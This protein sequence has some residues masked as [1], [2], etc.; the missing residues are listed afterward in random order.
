MGIV[1]EGLEPYQNRLINEVVSH[2]RRQVILRY[3]AGKSWCALRAADVIHRAGGR[4]RVVGIILCRNRNIM[5][6]RDEIEKRSTTP[7]RIRALTKNG[8]ETV[9]TST[10]AD[11]LFEAR[12]SDE[13]L[14]VP[15]QMV[16][17]HT[18]Y[19]VDQFFRNGNP[20]TLILDESTKIK[21]N[22]TA[23]AAS[24]HALA[25]E[26]RRLVPRGVR[27]GLT[28][29]ATP[30]GAYELW[31]QLEFVRDA[32]H[33]IAVSYWAMLTEYFTL[34]DRGY[35]LKP[36][37][38]AEFYER[39]GKLVAR[40][41]KDE[42]KALKAKDPTVHR[43][44]VRYELT[45]EQRDLRSQLLEK[46]ELS[47]G[48]RLD[49]YNYAMQLMAKDQQISNGFWR[50]A[51]GTTVYLKEN[52]KLSALE[53]IVQELAEERRTV[54]RRRVV[55]WCHY[56]EDYE[57][58]GRMLTSLRI[59]WGRGPS[60]AV[61]SLFG[62]GDFDY[63]LMPITVSEG[64]NIIADVS[65]TAIFFSNVPSI[66]TRDQAE[67]RHLRRNQTSP[68]VTFVDLCGPSARDEQIIEML[69]MKRPFIKD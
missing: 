5:T 64:F 47:N 58:I 48:D 15:H 12:V 9:H 20:M 8:M 65:D 16:E 36:Q 68:V 33:P 67:A 28:G 66:E 44:S 25:A 46:W 69:Q 10:D 26:H 24:I 32:R 34:S 4:G 27:I 17:R 50:T 3:G 19:I 35:V 29:N 62:L 55:I 54:E 52:P 57:M 40:M 39:A 56:E 18:A 51:E 31:S 61:M 63:L 53:D 13:W 41:T 21:N 30:E 7:P 1:T 60:D 22:R 42:W 45:R 37:K 43:L 11:T 38:H 6:W 2:G 14:I 49:M 23:R 59:S